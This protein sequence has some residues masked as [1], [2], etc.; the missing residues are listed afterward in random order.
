MVIDNAVVK[1]RVSVNKAPS[2]VEGNTHTSGELPDGV[3]SDTIQECNKTASPFEGNLIDEL[4]DHILVSIL[5][6]L[7]LKEAEKTSILS[8]RWRY[9]WTFTSRLV[10]YDS[11]WVPAVP[12][13]NGVKSL[14]VERS[15]F[16]KWVNSTLKFH[17]G[18]TIDEFGIRFPVGEESLSSEVVEYI[19]S[20]CPLLELLRVESSKTLEQLKVSGPAL[21]LKSLEISPVLRISFTTEEARTGLENGVSFAS[22]RFANVQICYV[23][24]LRF[25]GYPATD[26]LQCDGAGTT[27]TTSTSEER[28]ECK[29][30]ELL[31]AARTHAKQLKPRL[32]PG[33]E[34]AHF[35][36]ILFY[37][38][39]AHSKAFEHETGSNLDLQYFNSQAFP[40][41]PPPFQLSSF[42]SSLL[43]KYCVK[44]ELKMNAN[45]SSSSSSSSWTVS[46]SENFKFQGKGAT[47]AL[48]L[49]AMSVVVIIMIVFKCHRNHR[50]DAEV[51]VQGDVELTASS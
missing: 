18:T 9:L 22:P 4:P 51:D 48:L 8:H 3:V 23:T 26:T 5:S 21:N 50:N 39:T 29:D 49:L 32:P 45:N 11:L 31:L 43:R 38:W 30:D 28:F 37:F 40:P 17:Q 44:L 46:I 27:T 12:T 14:K 19:F 20:A 1:K 13:W 10:F 42:S 34:L 47:L 36:S 15:R 35:S 6:L 33:A 24:F 2:S 7:S 25:Q 16:I 41:A